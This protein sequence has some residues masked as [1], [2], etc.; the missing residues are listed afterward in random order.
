MRPTQ[1]LSEEV[2][3]KQENFSQHIFLGNL[4]YVIK[5]VGLFG[6]VVEECG[7]DAKMILMV[8]KETFSVDGIPLHIDPSVLVQNEKS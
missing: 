1:Q 4:F 2:F 3:L 8:E 5:V 7:W 6:L